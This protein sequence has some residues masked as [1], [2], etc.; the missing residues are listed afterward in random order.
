VGA[1]L[2]QPPENESDLW[3][4][5][6]QEVT[7][8]SDPAGSGGW[9][10]W[11][12]RP[13]LCD[14]ATGQPVVPSTPSTPSAAGA[15]PATHTTATAGQLLSQAV[16]LA[17]TWNETILFR[18]RWDG[19]FDELRQPSAA[20]GVP[21]PELAM[22]KRYGRA[23]WLALVEAWLPSAANY[24]T[25]PGRAQA[26]VALPPPSTPRLCVACSVSYRGVAH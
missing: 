26:R 12:K 19:R 13:T 10:V 4:Y 14:S 5:E 18:V 8:E 25:P 2:C 6:E 15:A 20:D 22:W 9:S 7:I 21:V 1:A 3:T 17:Q 23:I 11:V 24:P 16:P